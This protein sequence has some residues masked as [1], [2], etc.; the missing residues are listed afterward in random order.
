MRSGTLRPGWLVVAFLFVEG[1]QVSSWLLQPTYTLSDASR[2]FASTLDASDTILTS[3]E[4]L[5]IPSAANVICRSERRGFNLDA[6]KRFNPRYTLILRRDNWVYH[7]L[8]EM[9]PEEWPPPARF[10]TARVA[11]FDLC[12]TYGLG[13]RFTVELY[14]LEQQP[15]ATTRSER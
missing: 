6:Y 1:I 2:F 5:L 4:E 10:A 7:P 15:R 14:S 11:G 3:Y 12:P 9:V 13:P 8:E